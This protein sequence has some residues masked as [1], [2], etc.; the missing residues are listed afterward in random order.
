MIRMKRLRTDERGASV[1]E[2]GLTAPLLGFFLLGSVDMGMGYSERLALQQAATRTIEM[3]SMRGQVNGSYSYLQSHAAA[4]SGEPTSHV[5]VD[6]WL[7]CDDVRQSSYDGV[8]GG[9]QQIARYIS[10]RITGSHEPLFDYSGLARRFG[11]TG[12]AEDIAIAGE[13]TVRVQ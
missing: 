10:I 6:N 12:L 8:C 13:A 4:A 2:L 5:T 1:I 3:A 7:A 11:A 9:N